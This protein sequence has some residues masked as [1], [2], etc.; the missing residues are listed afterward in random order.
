MNDININA[1]S[2]SLGVGQTYS[3]AN[4]KPVKRGGD[5]PDTVQLSKPP[6]LSAIEAALEEE[7]AGIRSK[8]E[9]DVNAEN[10]PPLET[11]DRLAAMFAI[12]LKSEKKP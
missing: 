8:M 1:L 4:Q 2:R 9:D 6:D 7:F 5:E 3:A 11:I 10:Y 12:N